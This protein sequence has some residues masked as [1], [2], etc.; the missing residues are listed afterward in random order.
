MENHK[1]WK[2]QPIIN[3][4]TTKVEEDGII[5]IIDV[6]GTPKEPYKLPDGYEWHTLDLNDE[7]DLNNITKYSKKTLD[8]N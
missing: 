6:E 1:F 3:T 5:Q 2:T 7:T 8:K 4:K